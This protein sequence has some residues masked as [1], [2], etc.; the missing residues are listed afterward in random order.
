MPI[1]RHHM[2]NGRHRHNKSI[3]TCLRHDDGVA[4]PSMDEQDPRGCV[5]RHKWHDVPILGRHSDIAR[6]GYN[7]KSIRYGQGS[8]SNVGV[9][10]CVASVRDWYAMRTSWDHCD[11]FGSFCPLC[12]L[13]GI[14]IYSQERYGKDPAG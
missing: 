2:P 10:G 9:E 6:Q 1:D 11:C 12:V 14:E 4:V 3:A 8:E 13:V 7:N 5:P